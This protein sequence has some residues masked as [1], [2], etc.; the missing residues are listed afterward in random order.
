MEKDR[1][2]GSDRVSETRR[3]RRYRNAIG[4]KQT[5]TTEV[6]EKHREEE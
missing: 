3:D 5:G 6:T 2:E 4:E 1:G